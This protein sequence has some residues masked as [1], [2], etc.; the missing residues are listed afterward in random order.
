MHESKHTQAGPPPTLRG[1]RRSARGAAPVPAPQF[2]APLQ[3]SPSGPVVGAGVADQVWGPEK[4]ADLASLGRTSLRG[5]KILVVEDHPD[6]RELTRQMLAHLGALVTVAADGAEALREI[7]RECPD[8][9]LCDLVMPVLDGYELAQRV[10]RM[11]ECARVRLVALT[12]LRDT[13]AWFRTW[14]VGY[15]AHLEKPLSFEK[16]ER[17]ADQVLLECPKPPR[18]SSKRRPKRSRKAN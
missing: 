6:N 13:T 3:I 10:R 2:G 9:I 14:S 15:D 4:T 5:V 16:L 1:P 7:A 12:A 18:S 17:I 11:P 8:L